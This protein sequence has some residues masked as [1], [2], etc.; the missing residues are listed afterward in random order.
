M[1]QRLQPHAP[2]LQPL[3]NPAIAV[4]AQERVSATA[5]LLVGL[6]PSAAGSA[7]PAYAAA[8]RL[9]FGVR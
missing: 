5:M 6:R 1:Y 9:R 7:L 4:A 8:A 3:R 2:D